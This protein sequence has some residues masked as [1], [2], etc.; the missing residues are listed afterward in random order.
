MPRNK[1]RH[2]CS[3]DVPVLRGLAK[4]GKFNYYLYSL[5]GSARLPID[6]SECEREPICHLGLIQPHGYLLA[7]NANGEISHASENI[8][9]LFPLAAR[10]ALG[11]SLEQ[12]AGAQAERLLRQASAYS[13]GQS[14]HEVWEQDAQPYSLWMHARDGKYL[15]EWEPLA[16]DPPAPDANQLAAGLG[17]IREAANI[18]RQAKLAAE[19]VAQLTGFDR[20]MIYQFLPDA[21]GEVI[22]E[23]RQPAAEPFLGL[24]YPASDIP[25]QARKLYTETL[26]RVL[27]DVYATPVGIL[28]RPGDAAPL[29]LT[30]SQLRAMSP[31]HI[32]YL[33]N[34]KVGATAT[35]SLLYE[36]ALWGLM[37]CHHDRRK[38]VVPAEKRAL[39]EIA[40]TLRAGIEAAVSRARQRSA[41]RLNGRLQNLEATITS[42]A[43]ALSAILSDPNVCVTCCMAAAPLFGAPPDRCG[44]AKRRRRRNWKRVPGICS[45]AA[46]ILRHRFAHRF[47]RPPGSCS[48]GVLACRAHRHGCL[49]R[50]RSHLIRLPAR[51]DPRS[52]LGR[53]YQSACFAR[54][55]HRA[56]QSTPFVCPV[57]TKRVGTAAP[58]TEE[59]LATAHIVIRVLRGKGST[60]NDDASHR[61]W[62]CRHS[63]SR[64]ERLSSAQHASRRPERWHF[65]GVP[66]RPGEATL[67]YANQSLLELAETFS[68]A[69]EPWPSTHDLLAAFGL[70]SDVL[71]DSEWTPR[72]V[73]IPTA[74]E[75]LRHFL[76]EKKLALEICDAQG[77]VGLSA[78][79]FTDTT[80]IERARQAFQAAD[81]KAKHLPS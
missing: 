6:L 1:A 23:V 3:L 37:A 29:D 36:G 70:P 16:A 26:L 74:R 79:F 5:R 59:D 51:G 24:R 40:Q 34:L 25:P 11:L 22:A 52:H 7:V 77:T 69:G 46:R 49:A 64:H 14:Q 60:R 15:F 71:A 55:S 20:I 2:W 48:A 73:V 81:E 19:L 33:K 45:A 9:Q 41:Q 4:R 76:V 63:W 39:A 42:P 68:E 10:E 54:R 78:I 75:G 21:S 57:Q 38:V 28:A 66:L 56:L 13:A 58:W 35:V 18:H 80:R 31:Y 30:L 27:V 72:Q 43:I 50:T 8:G 44:W 65:F 61:R 12:V 32:E 47:D 53:R 67:R 17:L 62:L